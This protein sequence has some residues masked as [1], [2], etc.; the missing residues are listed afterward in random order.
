VLFAVWFFYRR[1][2]RQ[3][4]GKISSHDVGAT[5]RASRHTEA[6]SDV[7]SEQA[8]GLGHQEGHAVRRRRARR[9]SRSATRSRDSP[10]T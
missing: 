8:E 3:W 10:S 7:D 1:E 9:R 6:Q 4:Q 2:E 5:P